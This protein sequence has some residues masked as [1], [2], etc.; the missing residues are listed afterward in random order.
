M[1]GALPSESHEFLQLYIYITPA[2]CFTEPD[3]VFALYSDDE[4]PR[5]TIRAGYDMEESMPGPGLGVFPNSINNES[6]SR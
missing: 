2:M 5:E 3:T 6:I 4:G 1:G